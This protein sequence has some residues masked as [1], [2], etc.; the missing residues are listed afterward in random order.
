MS[1]P[2][3]E[4]STYSL[5]NTMTHNRDMR[6]SLSL[7]I[8]QLFSG[9][10][11]TSS[12]RD[13]C[14]SELEDPVTP[15]PVILRDVSVQFVIVSIYSCCV[16]VCYRMNSVKQFRYHH[17]RSVFTS[18][19]VFLRCDVNLNL[20]VIWFCSTSSISTMSDLFETVYRRA[21]DIHSVS[22]ASQKLSSGHVLPHGPLCLSV[23]RP[24]HTQEP[25]TVH[26]LALIP[27]QP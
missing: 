23:C 2:S 12:L 5:N 10:R 1:R 13:N 11:C 16:F 3:C 17:K 18:E 4:C 27:H 25:L 24:G 8:L 14:T 22:E 9:P 7:S 26:Q 6:V 21:S 20:Y 19:Q 15:P